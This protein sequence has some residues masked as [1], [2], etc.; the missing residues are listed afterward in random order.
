[1]EA[2]SLAVVFGV[3]RNHLYLYGLAEFTVETDH[4]PLVD[5]YK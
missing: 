4:K 5:L 3:T 1:M 2:E